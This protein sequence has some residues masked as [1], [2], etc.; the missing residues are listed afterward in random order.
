M[1]LNETCFKIDKP[2]AYAMIYGFRKGGKLYR[3]SI[4]LAVK[5]WLTA[6]DRV[7]SPLLTFNRTPTRF[8]LSRIGEEMDAED[9]TIPFKYIAELDREYFVRNE[10]ALWKTVCSNGLFDIWNPEAPNKR[11]DQAKSDSAKFRIQLLRIY[12]INYEFNN[13]DIRH[14]SARVDK[15]KSSN[16]EVS[17]IGPVISNEEFRNMKELLEHSITPYWKK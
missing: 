2:N 12:E 6:K 3:Q 4:W 8:E 16:I 10:L 13:N 17:K 11:F 9:V 5:D 14:A 7:S 15:L 1:Q